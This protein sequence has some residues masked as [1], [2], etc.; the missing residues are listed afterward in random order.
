M[1]SEP[2]LATDGGDVD[3]GEA[4]DGATSDA[5]DAPPDACVAVAETCDRADNDCDGRVDEDLADVVELCN[6]RDDD[7]DGVADEGLGVGSTC[8]GADSDACHE[9][10]IG[11]APDGTTMC[12]DLTPGTVELCNGL[13]DDCQNGADDTFPIGQPC[14]AGVGACARSGTLVCNG[15]GT[16]TVC[17]A[18]AAAP[19]PELCGNSIDEDC[20][21][22]DVACPGNDRPAGAI[23]ISAGGTFTVDLTAAHDD[24]WAA[25]TATLDCGDP[26]GRDAFYQFTLP[27]EEVVYF[28]SFGSNFDTVI[29]VFAGACTSLGSTKACADDACS[30]T[31]SQ[32]AIDLPAGTYCLVIDQFSASTTAGAASLSFE[33]G[34]RSG[35][36]LPATSG[37]VTGTTTGKANQSIAG[38]EPNSSQPDVGYFFLT[39]PSRTYTVSANTC[40]TTAFDSILYLRRGAAT[41]GD[42]VCSDDETGCG[43]G[44]QAKITNASMTGANLNWMIVDGF[45]QTGNGNYTLTYSVQ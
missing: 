16:G 42:L 20:N 14:S 38:C 21:G 22:A 45:G 6:S 33:R 8:D 35:L 4:P 44:L 12:S 40:S 24:N 27:A 23:D 28:D 18:S 32:G 17:S 13:D 29:R 31:R 3:S 11:C 30:T 43:N 39:C 5:S 19:V 25:S 7:C 9:G 34:G 37:S 1:A 2:R 36:P 26:G 10:L 15:S 41:A